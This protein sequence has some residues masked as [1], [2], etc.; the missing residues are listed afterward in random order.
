[1]LIVLGLDHMLHPD[2]VG[3]APHENTERGRGG[4]EDTKGTQYL[5]RLA[6]PRWG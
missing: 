6:E 2:S 1:M 3:T 5:S 4:A